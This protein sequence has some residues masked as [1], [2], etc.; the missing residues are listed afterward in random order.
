MW[1]KKSSPSIIRPPESIEEYPRLL[2]KLISYNSNSWSTTETS[3]RMFYPGQLGIDLFNKPAERLQWQRD[4]ILAFQIETWVIHGEEEETEKTNMEDKKIQHGTTALTQQSDSALR[5]IKTLTTYFQ[6]RS[7]LHQ[8]LGISLPKM[9]WV[10]S[11]R[12]RTQPE[13][14]NVQAQP[15]TG[16]VQSCLSQEQFDTWRVGAD[17]T[18]TNSPISSLPPQLF[19]SAVSPKGL[20]YRINI[21]R[22]CQGK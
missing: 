15:G 21:S 17:T 1:Y 13:Q 8:F 10:W 7:R 16:T 6:P 22:L 18:P 19:L 11:T 4:L 2:V 14:A 5:L 12:S 9:F 20:R 3:Q